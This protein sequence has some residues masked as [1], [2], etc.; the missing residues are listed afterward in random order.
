MHGGMSEVDRIEYES[1]DIKIRS[2]EHKINHWEGQDALVREMIRLLQKR[3]SEAI[4]RQKDL[5]IKYG[6]SVKSESA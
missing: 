4:T 1:L 3:W 5:Q 2:L 6:I